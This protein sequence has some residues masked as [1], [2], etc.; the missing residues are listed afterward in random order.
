MMSFTPNHRAYEVQYSGPQLHSVSLW[1]LVGIQVLLQV[2]NFYCALLES[3]HPA[4]ILA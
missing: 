3:H 1:I 2:R 4:E